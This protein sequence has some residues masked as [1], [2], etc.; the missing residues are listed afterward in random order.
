MEV[1]RGDEVFLQK[2]PDNIYDQNAVRFL[3]VSGK[4]LGYLPRYYNKEVIELL[5]YKKEIACHIYNV[6]RNKN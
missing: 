1:T 5:K 6:N 3:D 4:V 2:E